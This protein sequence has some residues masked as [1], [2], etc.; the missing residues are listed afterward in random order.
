MNE[1]IAIA[2]HLESACAY[3]REHG[4]TRGKYQDRDGSVCA[5][6]ALMHAVGMTRLMEPTVSN[7]YVFSPALMRDTTEGALYYEIIDIV[8][9]HLEEHSTASDILHFND[10]QSNTMYDVIDLYMDVAMNLRD[11]EWASQNR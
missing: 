5:L 1:N 2:E 3:M 10:D 7:S 4:W 9:Q 6:G 8:Q 11:S